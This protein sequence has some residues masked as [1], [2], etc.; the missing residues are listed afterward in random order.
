[1]ITNIKL[2]IYQAIFCIIKLSYKYDNLNNKFTK[3]FIY[4][5]YLKDKTSIY[6]DSYQLLTIIKNKRSILS[7]SYKFYVF[8]NYKNQQ[9]IYGDPHLR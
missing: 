9:N 8:F 6:I 3:K 1:M 4:F 7:M 2:T 5:K